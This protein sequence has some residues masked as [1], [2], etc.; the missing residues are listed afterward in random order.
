MDDLTS[1]LA[2]T[3]GAPGPNPPPLR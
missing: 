2:L 3:L 1:V